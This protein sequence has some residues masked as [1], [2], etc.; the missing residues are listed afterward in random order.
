MSMLVDQRSLTTRCKHSLTP[1]NSLEPF[2]LFQDLWTE[3]IRGHLWTWARAS[4]LCF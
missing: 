1:V 4:G 2:K 3:L